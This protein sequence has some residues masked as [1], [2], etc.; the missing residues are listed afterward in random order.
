[1][2]ILYGVQGTGNGHISR[3]RAMAQALSQFDVDVDFVFSGRPANQYF[4]M[5]VFGNY[6]TF[7][8]MSFV[9]HAGKVD[10]VKTATD[11]NIWQM[12]RDIR[13]LDVSG[14]DKVVSDFEPISAWAAKRQ[15]VPSVS[16]SHQ[17]AMRYPIPKQGEGALNRLIMRYFAP[18]EHHIGLH[19]YHFDQPIFPPIIDISATDKPIMGDAVLVYLPFEDLDEVIQMLTRFSNAFICF[20]PDAKKEERENVSL[21]PLSK[22]D[23]HQA[24]I[25]CRGVIANGGFE[26]PSEALRLGKKLLLKPLNGQFEQ[27][28]NVMTLELLGLGKSMSTLDATVIR[29][30]LDKPNLGR[31]HYP[32]VAHALATWLVNGK[33]ERTD[34]LWHQLWSQVQFPEFVDEMIG[35]LY[36]GDI[37]PPVKRE[38]LF[39]T[40]KTV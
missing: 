8:G 16:I 29:Q 20:H 12:W 22:T 5:E 23:F 24:L 17:S 2:K 14:Y 32:D 40:R 11:N 19:W 7:R 4:D 9:S 37:D 27:L 13:N 31:V 26:L 39:R 34:E 1:M 3:A 15:G 38:S 25:Q 30:W 18:T 28:S 21:R 36:Q 35:D 33:L 10:V 6:R